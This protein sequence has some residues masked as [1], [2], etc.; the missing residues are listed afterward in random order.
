[1]AI[2]DDI[3]V[4][5]TFWIYKGFKRDILCPSF[6]ILHV[7]STFCGQLFVM[8]TIDFI[9]VASFPNLLRFARGTQLV[10]IPYFSINVN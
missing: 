10:P 7:F 2:I 6:T 1:M 3:P 5:A 9:F 4:V 8:A